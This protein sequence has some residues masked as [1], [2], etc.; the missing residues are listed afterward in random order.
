MSFGSGFIPP[1]VFSLQAILYD[2][3]ELMYEHM[4]DKGIGCQC[5]AL[6]EAWA[7]YLELLGNTKKADAI[8]AEG[9][10]RKAEPFD[11]LQ[12]RHQ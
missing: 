3:P 5:A 7:S 10:R 12:K 8:F 9:L 1:F 2:T 11:V 4:R 6:Y